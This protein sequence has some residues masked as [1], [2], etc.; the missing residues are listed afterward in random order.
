[1][2]NQ[3]T[4]QVNA[5]HVVVKKLIHAKREAVF[6]AWTKPELLQ[7]WL[8]GGERWSAV[9]K[10]DLRVGGK[11]SHEMISDGTESPEHTC[12]TSTQGIPQRYMHTGEYLEI[13]RPEKLVFTWNSAAVKNTRVTVLLRET[14]EGTEVTVTHELLK[15]EKDIA[16]HTAGWMRCL[17]N[18][19]PLFS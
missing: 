2:E 7:K 17:E 1:M 11:Y 16:S 18:L 3:K 12:G 8:Y 14:E 10:N 13:A 15:T 4:A 19:V 9:T 6:D 5:P